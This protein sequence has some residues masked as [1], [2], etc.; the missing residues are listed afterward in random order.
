MIYLLNREGYGSVPEIL[1]DNLM[2]TIK[3]SNSRNK[4]ERVWTGNALRS[5]LVGDTPEELTKSE[6]WYMNKYVLRKK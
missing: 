1:E 4:M 6:M 5:D 2:N 3:F